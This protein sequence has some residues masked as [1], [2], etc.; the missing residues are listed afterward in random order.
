MSKTPAAPANS[1]AVNMLYI[2]ILAALWGSSFI[3]MK[4]GLKGFDPV[5]VACW[6]IFIAFLALLPLYARFSVRAFNKRHYTFLPIVALFGSGIPPF[7]FTWAQ[8]HIAS[9]VA[10]VIN[11]L[12]P[13]ATLLFGFFLFR[14]KVR[15]MQ[16]LGVF[17]GLSGAVMVI[18]FNANFGLDQDFEYGLLVVLACICYGLGANLLKEKLYDLSPLA[19]T[20]VG[21]SFIGPPC[22]FYLWYSGAFELALHNPASQTALGYLLILGI[23]GT[24]FALVLFN[25]LIKTIS[26][27]YASTVTYLIPIVA[28]AWGMFDGE[29]IGLAHVIG[30]ALILAGIRLTGKKV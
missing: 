15:A 16:V 21:F 10:G 30:L 12:T 6:R 22:G 5:Q 19:I 25:Y 1:S 20:A 26:A 18:L 23:I 7:L 9:Y 14:T 13:L 17:V 27:L 4:Q 28:V 29:S 2:G 8:T 24:A 11:A 3:L